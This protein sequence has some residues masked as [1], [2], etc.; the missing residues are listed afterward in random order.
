MAAKLVPKLSFK[1]VEEQPIETR[2]PP[3]PSWDSLKHDEVCCL[4]WLL[5]DPQG[6]VLAEDLLA[7]REEIRASASRV[8]ATVAEEC[9]TSGALLIPR[10]AGT[11]ASIGNAEDGI[12]KLGQ[13]LCQW[14]VERE[15]PCH[16][17]VGVHTGSL[18]SCV[19][20][21]DEHPSYFGVALSTARMLAERSTMVSCVNLSW[22]TKDRLRLMENAPLSPSVTNNSYYL[23]PWAGA[24]EELTG[25][26]SSR[27]RSMTPRKVLEAPT[28]PPQADSAGSAAKPTMSLEEFRDYLA[29]NGVDIWAFGRGQAKTIE[30][31]YRTVQIDRTSTLVESDGHLKHY[32]ELL[33]I[34]LRAKDAQGTEYQLRLDSEIDNGRAMNRN[35]KPGARVVQPWSLD[36]SVVNCL[37]KRLG[38]PPD[39]QAQVL[40]LDE[41]GSSHEERE[42]DSRSIPDITTTSKVHTVLM[43][44]KDLHHPGLSV[45]GLPS[46]GP[47]SNQTTNWSWHPVDKVSTSEDSL[48]HLLE[49]HG[50]NIGDITA[51][52]LADLCDEVADGKYATLSLRQDNQLERSINVLKVWISAEVLCSE[53]VL[54]KQWDSTKGAND[55]HE[56]QPVNMRMLS[57]QRWQDAVKVALRHQVGLDNDFQDKHLWL[58]ER[59][60]RLSEEVGYSRTYA[61]LRTV[62]RLHEVSV[63]VRDPS[64]VGLHLLGLPQGHD[65][66]TKHSKAAKG[67]MQNTKI[68]VVIR[69]A[70]KPLSSSQSG[71]KSFSRMLTNSRQSGMSIGKRRLPA[72]S[73]MEVPED[74][75]KSGSLLRDLMRA[76]ETKWDRAL[77]AARRIRDTH[78]TCRHFYEDCVAAFPELALYMPIGGDELETSSGRTGDDEY[79]RTLGALF[80]VYWFMRLDSDGA[81]SFCFGVDNQWNPLTPDSKDPARPAAEIKKRQAFLD[82]A[83]WEKVEQLLVEAG[84]LNRNSDGELKHDTERTLAMIVLTVIHDIMKVQALCPVVEA[85]HAPFCGYDAGETIGDHDAALAYVLEHHPDAVPSFAE[86]PRV[87]KKTL[88]FTQSKMEFNMGWFTQAEAPPGAVFQ[89]FKAIIAAGNASDK[90]IAF[91]FVHFLTD[92]AGAEPCPLEG[93]EKFVLKFPLK[94]LMSFF[95]SFSFVEQ[96]SLKSETEVYEDYLKW[97]WK[98]FESSCGSVPSGSG[99]IARMRTLVMA[100][101]DGESILRAYNSLADQD[102]EVLDAELALTGSTGQSFQSEADRPSA[103]PAILVYYSPALMQLAGA[104]DP[105]GALH[106]LADVFRQARSLFP[107]RDDAVGETVIVRIDALKGLQV[108]S[109]FERLGPEE[110]WVLE[111]SAHREAQVR[112]LSLVELPR[113]NARVLFAPPQRAVMLVE[114]RPPPLPVTISAGIRES[115]SAAGEHPDTVANTRPPPPTSTNALGTVLL[116]VLNPIH[117]FLFRVMTRSGQRMYGFLRGQDIQ[118]LLLRHGPAIYSMLGMYCLIVCFDP[119]PARGGYPMGTHTNLLR[120]APWWKWLATYFPIRLKRTAKLNALQSYIF[121]CHPHGILGFGTWLN[122]GLNPTGADRL[123]EG[124]RLRLLGASAWFWIPLV[125][126]FAMLHGCG[127]VQRQAMLKILNRGESVVINAGGSREALDACPGTFRLQVRNRHGFI[128]C[129]LE[130][131]AHL[132]PVIS[133]GENELYSVYIAPTGSYLR[134]L[135][136]KITCFTGSPTPLFYGLPWLPAFPKSREV[137]TVVGE[138]IEVAKVE[139]YSQNDVEVLHERYIAALQALFERHKGEYG[140]AE[141]ALDMPSDGGE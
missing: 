47:F 99:S 34:D 129:A 126:E 10:G 19:F 68:E 85:E 131:G 42:M 20:V 16:L 133:F 23:E 132:V 53:H 122:F 74:L 54:T 76:K 28:L 17:R 55:R 105:D 84:L 137:I 50:V 94:V 102:S 121:V 117:A 98:E 7:L 44:V 3:A 9:A 43:R 67:S 31:F 45:I 81:Q 100:Q 87:Q 82:T 37:H 104:T 57:G 2:K 15:S 134:W 27:G 48:R 24:E 95:D 86:L 128:R 49:L 22:A 59:S 13:W 62:Y 46:M 35:Q 79:Q 70:W 5:S 39:L 69:W 124:V 41:A 12:V 8:E 29:K 114:S 11:K 73:P 6:R 61:G 110:A 64:L 112:K 123:F 116:W 75:G 88:I 136:E 51:E 97:R 93:C 109:I 26:L 101:G 4:V 106:V 78:Y 40:S 140:F 77:N 103:G 71:M 83:C 115:T 113:E 96:L 30:A 135:Q 90:D 33:R 141:L 36:E 139:N 52:A 56:D 38:L 58:D 18:S 60:Y 118:E 92:L 21:G 91:Y 111:R 127:C 66:T 72:P 25:P 32:V 107:L 119:Y 89:K 65:F 130:S 63:R 108:A 120:G 138:P 14:A 125:R 1:E 80:A